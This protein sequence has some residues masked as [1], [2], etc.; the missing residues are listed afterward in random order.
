MYTLL[1][2]GI[3]CAI[4]GIPTWAVV[5]AF[6]KAE[7]SATVYSPE[8]VTQRLRKGFFLSTWGIEL[9]FGALPSFALMFF[10]VSD[11][12]K[13]VVP[14]GSVIIGF[15]LL[16]A[17]RIQVGLMTRYLNFCNRKR[18]ELEDWVLSA[19]Q[20]IE[21]EAVRTNGLLAI[22]RAT[23]G[24]TDDMA[25]AINNSGVITG[26]MSVERVYTGK[27]LFKNHWPIITI[28]SV[29][30]ASALFTFAF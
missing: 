22:S 17:G 30:T 26:F 8:E 1:A 9:A 7:E 18:T 11:V 16:F 6:K 5:R 24:V 19:M 14:I 13:F 21:G 25:T 27:G 15:I 29:I 12:I 4:L 10:D 2:I 3:V 20:G 28:L 23:P